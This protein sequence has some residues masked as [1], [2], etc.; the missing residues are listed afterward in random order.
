MQP[1]RPSVPRGRPQSYYDSR[2]AAKPE[3]QVELLQRLLRVTYLLAL[4]F[5]GTVVLMSVVLYYTSESKSNL[6]T[7]AD[8]V[9]STGAFA[10]MHD[11]AGDYEKMRP[12]MSDSVRIFHLML[13]EFE[14]RGGVE[15]LLD[16]LEKG[17][18][19]IRALDDV[20]H[21]VRRLSGSA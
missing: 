12:E 7:L 1:P 14:R 21:F 19:S 15:R 18:D 6:D 3:T 2:R 11:A 16:M 9:R 13:A 20:V 17:D 8:D 10:A 4:L 5:L